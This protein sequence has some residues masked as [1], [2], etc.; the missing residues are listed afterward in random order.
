MLFIVT[1]L[2]DEKAL[3]S[4]ST[5]NHLIVV[6]KEEKKEMLVDATAL[7]N[8]QHSDLAVS[9]PLKIEHFISHHSGLIIRRGRWH[10]SR[11]QFKT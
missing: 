5:F 4:H 11:E 1:L 7:Y 6:L 9:I 10:E 3:R 2:S 8:R